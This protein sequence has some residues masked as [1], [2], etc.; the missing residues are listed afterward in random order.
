MMQKFFTNLKDLNL[1][2][3]ENHSTPFP[4]DANVRVRLE[5]LSVVFSS[6]GSPDDFRCVPFYLIFL[7]TSVAGELLSLLFVG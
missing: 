3:Q 7:S 6:I 1:K 5:F 4:Y 2:N